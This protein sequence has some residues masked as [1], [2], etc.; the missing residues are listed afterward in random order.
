MSLKLAIVGASGAV[1][2]EMLAELEYYDLDCEV[3]LF[4]SS[5][6]A[7][8]TL[9]YRGQVLGVKE[10]SLASIKGYDF[11]LMSAGGAFSTEFARSIVESGCQ[12]I[13]NSSAWRMAADV[14]LVVPEVNPHLLSKNPSGI[15]ANP[16]C[17]T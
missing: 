5:R 9:P 3:G 2:R 1:G 17:S 4:A 13:D 11:A 12:V 6:S 7:G 16:N 15:F 10:F 14:P 8:L